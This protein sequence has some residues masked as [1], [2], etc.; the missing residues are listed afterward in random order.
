MWLEVKALFTVFAMVLTGIV[1]SQIILVNLFLGVILFMAIGI[2]AFGDIIL[3]W[4]IT[5][6]NA[7]KVLDKPPPGQ[8]VIPLFTLTGMLDFVWAKKKP[9]GKREF[10]YHKE[11]ASLIDRGDYPIHMLNGGHGCIGL[12]SCDENI[13]MFEA[14]YADVLGKKLGTDNIKE[15]YA[16]AKTEDT[17]NEQ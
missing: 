9:H 11:E 3:G 12:E 1:I 10:V 17:K 5:R 14:K 2:Y 7:T 6:T 4:Q 15:I 16:I 8:T 13:N